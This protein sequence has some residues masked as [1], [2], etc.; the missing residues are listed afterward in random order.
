MYYKMIFKNKDYPCVKYTGSAPIGT[1]AKYPIFKKLA[2]LFRTTASRGARGTLSKNAQ[3]AISQQSP[4][5][6]A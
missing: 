5:V 1:V 2:K 3:K 4:I 6:N